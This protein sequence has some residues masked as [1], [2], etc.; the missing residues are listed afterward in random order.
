MQR[1]EKSVKSKY[2]QLNFK[3]DFPIVADMSTEKV[4]LG[5]K[6]FEEGKKIVSST[7]KRK[8]KSQ[9][10]GTLKFTSI[11]RRFVKPRTSSVPAVALTTARTTTPTTATERLGAIR[12]F[13]K[14]VRG[15]Q[16][17]V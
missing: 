2:P 3:L 4:E 17:D 14:N 13:L 6:Y 9:P 15:V 8:Y 10:V 11:I 5:N 12:G 1:V 16:V 7:K